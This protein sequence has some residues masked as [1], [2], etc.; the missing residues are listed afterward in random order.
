MGP[1][2][3]ETSE[4]GS[5][6]PGEDQGESQEGSGY[7]APRST[8]QRMHWLGREGSR[9]PGSKLLLNPRQCNNSGFGMS[10]REM[11]RM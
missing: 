8:G 11:K 6:Q 1:W 10:K 9:E 5:G 7:A 2:R 3:P 4:K